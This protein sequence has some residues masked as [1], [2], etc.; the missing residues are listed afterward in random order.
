[1]ERVTLHG[2]PLHDKEQF[3]GHVAGRASRNVTARQEI[4]CSTRRRLRH[5][6]YSCMIEMA[7]TVRSGLHRTERLCMIGNDLHG[8]EQVA[9]QRIFSVS[10]L[11]AYYTIKNE[12]QTD[13]LI[14]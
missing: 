5:T 2:T 11:S 4:A 9:P 3:A 1:M 6:E 14:L 10:Y 8:T 7:C 13:T 12:L